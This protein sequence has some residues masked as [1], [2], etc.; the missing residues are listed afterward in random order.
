MESKFETKIKQV[1]ARKRREK[2]LGALPINTV[3]K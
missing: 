3:N 1:E 2:L